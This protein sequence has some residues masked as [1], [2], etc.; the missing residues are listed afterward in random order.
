[1]G[2]SA[3]DATLPISLSLSAV[4]V[5]SAALLLCSAAAG[6]CCAAA[7]LLLLSFMVYVSYLGFCHDRAAAEIKP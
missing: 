1:M 4:C 6:C 5:Q 2:G 7:A 3:D